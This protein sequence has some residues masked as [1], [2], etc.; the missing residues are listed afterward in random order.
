M[1][2]KARIE[3][4]R[5]LKEIVVLRDF[6]NLIRN[7]EITSISDAFFAAGETLKEADRIRTLPDYEV[8]P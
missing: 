7:A 6:V 3:T 1:D 4:A 8:L 2:E 5:L